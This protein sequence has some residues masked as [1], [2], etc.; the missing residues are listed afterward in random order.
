MRD[1]R[2]DKVVEAQKDLLKEATGLSR[3][4]LGGGGKETGRAPTVGEEQV[5]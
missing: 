4:L 5:S 2:R 1:R 3:Q